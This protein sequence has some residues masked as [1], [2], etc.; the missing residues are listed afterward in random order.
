MI[1]EILTHSEQQTVE[2][3]FALAQELSAGDVVALIGDLGAGKTHLTKGICKGLGIHEDITSPTFVILNEYMSG[4]LPA[5]HFD[6]YRMRSIS[7]LEEIGFEEYLYR[8]GVC[9]IEWAD[10]VAMKLPPR[11]YEAR[12]RLGDSHEDRIITI[13]KLG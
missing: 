2:A 13:E 5:F 9:I 8:E 7:E 10:M 11:R 4:R 12:L 1:K 3:G 6:F